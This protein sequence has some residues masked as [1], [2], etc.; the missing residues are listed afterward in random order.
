MSQLA[1]LLRDFGIR[2]TTFRG[3]AS[4]PKGYSVADL[5]K[6]FIRYLGGIHPQHPQQAHEQGIS[7]DFAAA[8]SGEMLRMQ[9]DPESAIQADFADVADRRGVRPVEWDVSDVPEEL[10]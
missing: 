3:G 7:G 4:T 9:F 10:V 1:N 5:E 8:T 6:V 2:S